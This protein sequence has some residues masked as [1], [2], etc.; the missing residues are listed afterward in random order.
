[1]PGR[2]RAIASLAAAALLLGLAL[3]AVGGTWSANA[4]G[5]RTVKIDGVNVLANGKGY[6]L[7]WFA[8]DTAAKSACHGL[9]PAYW[10]P[11]NGGL[12]AG[13]CGT[14]KAGMIKRSDGST[15]ATYDG[16]PLYTYV[17]DSAPGQANGNPPS[18]NGGLWH[19][20]TFPAQLLQCP[21]TSPG[22][23]VG[24]TSRLAGS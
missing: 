10:P 17:G 2:G 20:I 15:Q 5:M 13:P 1:M 8:A 7:Y 16:H 21:A 11:V 22:I 3:A 18:M 14:G 24:R 12:T 6:T 9:C 4:A 23:G 19:E